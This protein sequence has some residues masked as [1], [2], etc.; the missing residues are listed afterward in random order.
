MNESGFCSSVTALKCSVGVK[1]SLKEA[2]KD[3]KPN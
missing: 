2:E 1:F 3:A